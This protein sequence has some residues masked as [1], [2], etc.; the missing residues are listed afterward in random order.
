[1][2]DEMR[3]AMEIGGVYRTRLVPGPGDEEVAHEGMM[4][5]QV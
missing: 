3:S 5:V 1:M 2:Y 4:E